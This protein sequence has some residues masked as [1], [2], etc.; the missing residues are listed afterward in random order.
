MN[1]PKSYADITISQY[2]KI[3]TLTKRIKDPMELGMNLLATLKGV[4]YKEI[5]N[6]P[7]SK[8]LAE[9]KQLE[10]LNELPADKKIR[11]SFRLN[12][13]IYKAILFHK[14]MTAGQFI[15]FSSVCKDVP[16]EDSIYHIHE[17]IACMCVR[18][19]WQWKIP[20]WKWVYDGY[21]DT[22][23]LF[24]D[25]MT[26]NVA[27]PYFLFFCN[28]SAGLSKAIADYSI[29]RTIEEIGK[30]KKMIKEFR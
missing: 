24:Y 18:R 25:N 28:V 4:S 10:F 16:K 23:Q 1:L 3:Y 14:D 26:M 8:I 6:L 13:K 17:L 5:E 7:V 20:F 12:R 22:A 15:D 19:Q 27:Y 9:N 29:S 21:E 11:M 30:M 2:L